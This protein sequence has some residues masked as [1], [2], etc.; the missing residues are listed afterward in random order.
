LELYGTVRKKTT[1]AWIKSG[2]KEYTYYVVAFGIRGLERV[3]KSL[4]EG[5]KKFTITPVDNPEDKIEFKGAF[6]RIFILDVKIPKEYE[7][8]A[9]RNL[10]KRVKAVVEAKW[11]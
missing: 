3:D 1:R 9:K 4:L 6:K 2:I 7:E 10:R 11:K 5:V 8:W